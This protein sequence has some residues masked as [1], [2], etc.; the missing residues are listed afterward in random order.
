[1]KHDCDIQSLLAVPAVQSAR[2]LRFVLRICLYLQDSSS[3]ISLTDPV[4]QKSKA[5]K[6]ATRHEVIQ[7]DGNECKREHIAEYICRTSQL[8]K[9]CYTRWNVMTMR[10][11]GGR[12]RARLWNDIVKRGRRK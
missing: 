9:W 2:S 12:Y 11:S 10:K 5:H 4:T 7:N 1:V 3:S 8:R 6:W